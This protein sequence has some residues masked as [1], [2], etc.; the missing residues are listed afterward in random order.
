MCIRDSPNS[1]ELLRKRTQVWTTSSIMS[2]QLEQLQC[3]GTHTHG[4]I[5]GT[6][7]TPKGGRQSLSK[8]TENYTYVFARHLSRIIRCSL[9]VQEQHDHKVHDC[10]TSLAITRQGSRRP[11]ADDSKPS[12]RPRHCMSHSGKWILDHCLKLCSVNAKR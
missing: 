7:W 6:C 3:T 9:Q 10:A 11:N 5:A 4:L 1:L 8:Y 2:A 12:L